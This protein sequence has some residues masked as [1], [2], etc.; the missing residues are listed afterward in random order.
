[1]YNIHIAKV[2]AADRLFTKQRGQNPKVNGAGFNAIDLAKSFPGF[3]SSILVLDRGHLQGYHD[4][5]SPRGFLIFFFETCDADFV[6][7][8]IS[9]LV[10]LNKSY[11]R[12]DRAEYY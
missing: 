6:L 9:C 5:I 7:L 10:G 4:D 8:Q 3:Q 12:A 2:V 11:Y 1:M